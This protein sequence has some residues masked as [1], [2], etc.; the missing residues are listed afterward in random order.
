[1]YDFQLQLCHCAEI[2]QSA[3]KVIEDC[4]QSVLHGGLIGNNSYLYHEQL[5][6]DE[7]RPTGSLAR[8]S[9]CRVP[10]Q[11]GSN[12][13][14]EKSPPRPPLNISTFTTGISA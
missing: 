2:V 11:F 9:Q 5:T 12:L 8:S 1:V 14:F 6:V 4:M 10:D 7:V 13:F 3:E